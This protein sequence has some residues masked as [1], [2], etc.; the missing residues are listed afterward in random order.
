[1]G[2]LS[3]PAYDAPVQKRQYDAIL[4]TDTWQDII[5]GG[6]LR[7]PQIAQPADSV[8]PAAPQGLRVR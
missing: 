2:T 7:D 3:Q 8:P 5:D 4:I 1:M 6:Y